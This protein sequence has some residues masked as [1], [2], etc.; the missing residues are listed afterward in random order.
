MYHCGRIILEG[1]LG[2]N[3]PE[4]LGFKTVYFDLPGLRMHAPV[5]GPEDGPLVVL[6]HGFPEFW[7]GRE[8]QIEPLA[9]AGFRVVVPDQRGYNL[10]DKTSPFDTRT[11]S[12]DIVNLIE[13]CGRE[14]A[15]VAGH[16]WGAAVAWTLAGLQPRCVK[17]L[18]ILNVPHPTAMVQA[19]AEG[20]VKQL[21]GVLV[22]VALKPTLG[23]KIFEFLRCTSMVNVC[24]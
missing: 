2:M 20:N 6:L 7:Y 10:T 13:S 4:Q 19:F 12:N 15:F 17:K 8:H 16:D 24:P 22:E 11:L 14:D 18:A 1:L 3:L 5:A 21:F 23:G 9:Q